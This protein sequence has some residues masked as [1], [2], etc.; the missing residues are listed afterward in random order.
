MDEEERIE[1]EIHELLLE[2]EQLDPIGIRRAR[3]TLH[4]KR[5]NDPRHCTP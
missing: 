2:L 4:D 5:T 3:N 1:Y